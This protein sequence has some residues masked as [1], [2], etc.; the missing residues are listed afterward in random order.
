MV[1]KGPI[2]VQSVG[3]G[4]FALADYRSPGQLFELDLFERKQTKQQRTDNDGLCGCLADVCMCFL[5][6]KIHLSLPSLA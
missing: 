6:K 3:F 2:V 5:V 4:S 1:S